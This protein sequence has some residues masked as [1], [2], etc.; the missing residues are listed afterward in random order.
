MPRIRELTGLDPREG[1]LFPNQLAADIE[2]KGD[3][4]IHYNLLRPVQ[5]ARR[6]GLAAADGFVF[7]ND[8]K[9][10]RVLELPAQR[11]AIVLVASRDTLI[12]RARRRAHNEMDGK[13]YQHEKW[14]NLLERVDLDALYRT[15]REELRTRDIP[16]VELDAESADLPV[17]SPAP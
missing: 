7:S 13:P 14:L 16:F 15:W 11:Q 3:G 4:F 8:P 5:R 10:R 2:L 1:V 12:G 9:W 6:K 17:L